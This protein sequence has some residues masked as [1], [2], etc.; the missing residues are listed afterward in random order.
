MRADRLLTILLLLQSSRRLT[1]RQLAQRLEV[2]E[3]TIHRDMEALGIAGVP[4]VAERGNGGGWALLEPYRTDLHGLNP[5]EAE[6]L[7]LAQPNQ[8]LSDLGMRQ[9]ADSA[10]TKLLAA[11]PSLVRRN[12]EL[13]RQRIHVDGAG[14][15]QWEEQA[16]ALPTVQRA[17]WQARKL[18]ITY[19]RTDETVVQRLVDPLGLVA[20]GSVW[21]LVAAVDGAIRTYR[22][23]RIQAAQITDEP[24]QRPAD[25]DLATY[26]E[27]SQQ[28]FQAGLP[29]YVA[30]L[31]IDSAILPLARTLWRFTRI[32]RIEPPDANGWQEI[33]VDF[34]VEEEARIYILGLGPQVEVL[35]PLSLRAKIIA[36]AEQVTARY[37]DIAPTPSLSGNA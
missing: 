36:A 24:C 20:K 27:A 19:G 13:V 33:E 25:F 31:R 29:H 17:L 6:A 12:A 2:S 26:W 14:W 10:L 11:L 7:A 21:Y 22:V 5:G 32:Q 35:A 8:L 23:G 30:T 34:G 3:R 28:A 16:P 18:V 37:Q 9:A 1:A 15:R 4:V